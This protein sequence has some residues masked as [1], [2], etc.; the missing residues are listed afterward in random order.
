[1]LPGTGVG[2]RLVFP[3]CF[4]GDFPGWG[5]C[6]LK[7]PKWLKIALSSYPGGKRAQAACGADLQ[8][9]SSSSGSA[10]A[11]CSPLRAAAC[12]QL[13]KAA[14]LPLVCLSQGAPDGEAGGWFSLAEMATWPRAI[15]SS[16]RLDR[17]G[18]CTGL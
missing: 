9:R 18:L 5:F 17:I 12:A 10:A 2:A 6:F 16:V 1:M 11:S 15:T 7:K 4:R 14:L 13:F 3:R 8:S